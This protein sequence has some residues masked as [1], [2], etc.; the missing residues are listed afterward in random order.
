MI[1]KVCDIRRLLYFTDFTFHDNDRAFLDFMVYTHP[2]QIPEEY[3]N[4]EV[5][6]LRAVHDRVRDIVALE[7][8][9]K[10]YD[11]NEDDDIV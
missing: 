3:L 11:A 4:M 1:V 10:K 5:V 6:G 9:I 7:I 2:D 8:H